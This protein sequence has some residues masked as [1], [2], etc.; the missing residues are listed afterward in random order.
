MSEWAGAAI[1]GDAGMWPLDTA[2]F[3]VKD[4]PYDNAVWHQ[5]Y[6]WDWEMEKYEMRKYWAPESFKFPA[7]TE[8]PFDEPMEEI[9]GVL[10]VNTGYLPLSRLPSIPPMKGYRPRSPALALV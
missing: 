1:R 10:G 5:E 9:V 6:R 3:Y 7:N 8:V 4:A 2:S